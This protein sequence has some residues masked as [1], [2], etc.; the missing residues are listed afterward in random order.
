MQQE[1][2]MFGGGGRGV[3]AGERTTRRRRRKRAIPII[4]FAAFI[5]LGLAQFLNV[6]DY[7]SGVNLS[8]TYL[9]SLPTT[10]IEKTHQSATS[11]KSRNDDT[12]LISLRQLDKRERMFR[13]GTYKFGPRHFLSLTGAS[14]TGDYHQQDMLWFQMFALGVDK[15]VKKKENGVGNKCEFLVSNHS[16]HNQS[17]EDFPFKTWKE[18]EQ[19]TLHCQ[20]GNRTTRLFLVPSDGIDANTNNLLQIW[21][22]LLHG[23]VGDKEE[24][25]EQTSSLLSDLDFERF[26]IMDDNT[27]HEQDLALPIQI[28]YQDPTSNNTEVL[29][30]IYLPIMEPSVGI[31]RIR[32]K[33]KK[34]SAPTTQK[35]FL[36]QRYIM[37]LCVLSHANGILRLNEFLQYHQDVLG[38]DHIHVAVRSTGTSSSNAEEQGVLR[39]ANHILQSDVKEGKVTLSTL[40]DD[41]LGIHCRDG[42]VPK[43]I[44]YQDCL[45]RAKSTSE[46][47]GT[48]DLDEFLVLGKN[49]NQTTTATTTGRTQTLTDMLRQIDHTSC[50]DWSFVT[51]KS[52]R[53]GRKKRGTVE[54]GSV[55][56]DYPVRDNVTDLIWQK[57]I[58]RTKNIFLNSFHIPGTALKQQQGQTTTNNNVMDAARL[59]PKDGECAFYLEEDEAVMVHF[60][61]RIEVQEPIPNELHL[62]LQHEYEDR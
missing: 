7:S 23:G 45:Y 59:H 22:C 10:A 40:W 16:Q 36:R 38:I 28:L 6:Y 46:F 1:W 35:P 39:A 26:R 41:S 11:T 27:I 29:T 60:N 51:I 50:P 18:M 32:S 21:R 62:M 9:F 52:S 8:H 47:V 49:F 44:F 2:Q 5:L 25:E 56:E 13:P 48:W 58:S 57:S 17:D 42:D 43:A 19:E 24:E 15:V 55:F 33:R 4:V 34:R 12:V 54:T 30:T 53:A 37:T 31:N 14:I 61:H 20:V 3:R